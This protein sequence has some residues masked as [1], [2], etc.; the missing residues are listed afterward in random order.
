MAVCA[1]VWTGG[2]SWNL[3]SR[4]FRR[5]FHLFWGRLT[6]PRTRLN[7]RT[8]LLC[9][10]NLTGVL[11]L[12]F[13]MVNEL[14]EQGIVRPSKSPYASPAFLVRKSGGGFRLVVDYRKVNAKVIFDSYPMPT[15]EQVFDQFG[16]TAVFTVLDLNSAYYQIPL[17]FK[18]RRN[19]LLYTFWPL[20]A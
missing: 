16:G 3:L 14:L 15:I 6:A 4:I 19:R 13:K 17:S 18:S 5:C 2:G 7:Y 11:R 12:N 8:L 10:R 9:V 20:S 1:E